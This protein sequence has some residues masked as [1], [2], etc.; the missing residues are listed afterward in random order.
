LQSCDTIVEKPHNEEYSVILL[1]RD[2]TIYFSF[3]DLI[4]SLV[5]FDKL[6]AFGCAAD[7][8]PGFGL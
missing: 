5:W 7:N 8:L 1:I 3:K 4:K 2:L 6:R